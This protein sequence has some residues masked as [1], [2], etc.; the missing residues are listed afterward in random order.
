MPRRTRGPCRSAAVGRRVLA[1][2]AHRVS[3][4][5]LCGGFAIFQS[6]TGYF[7]PQRRSLRW[8]STRRRWR[9]VELRK[10]SAS[11]FT[12]VWRSAGRC[13]RDR[14]V[15]YW[16]LA[17][18][19]ATRSRSRWALVGP[20]CISGSCGIFQSS[21]TSSW[22]TVISIATAHGMRD[23]CSC[24]AFSWRDCGVRRPS[25]GID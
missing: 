20:F 21:G 1:P 12:I 3:F 22:V 25:I 16:F 4:S 5:A 14:R 2:D 9:D 23:V 11:C 8:D 19:S 7:L 17:E 24:S 10:S 18:F 6:C 13:L 15:I